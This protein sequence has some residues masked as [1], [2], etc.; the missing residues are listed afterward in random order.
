MTDDPS[1]RAVLEQVRERRRRKRCPECEAIISIRG[2]RGEYHWQCLECEAL[3]IGYRTRAE[4]LD[5][6][7]GRR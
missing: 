4:A 3:G 5:G 7:S 6:A 2:F 1:V